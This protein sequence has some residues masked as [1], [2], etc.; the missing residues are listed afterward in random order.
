MK[1][2]SQNCKNIV[3]A[4]EI[5]ALHLLKE[6]QTL[7]KDSSSL[8]ETITKEKKRLVETKS[9]LE[10]ALLHSTCQTAVKKIKM[11][12]SKNVVDINNNSDSSD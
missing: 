3:K 9:K 6:A 12:N 5:K 10:A 4:N 7:M 11:S 8:N 2:R 1:I